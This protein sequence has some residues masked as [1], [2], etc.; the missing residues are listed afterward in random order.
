MNRSKENIVLLALRSLSCFLL[1]V[2]YAVTQENIG[3]CVYAS[4]F[5]RTARELGHIRKN[6]KP[7]KNKTLLEW[8]IVLLKISIYFNIP[9]VNRQKGKTPRFMSYLRPDCRETAYT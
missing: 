1:W 6:N 5:N 9:M 8:L 2:A 3:Y 7:L 4:N